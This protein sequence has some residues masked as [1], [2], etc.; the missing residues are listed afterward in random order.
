MRVRASGRSRQSDAWRLAAL[1]APLGLLVAAPALAQQQTVRLAPFVRLTETI[2]DNAGLRNDR[3]A[4]SDWITQLSPGVSLE[5]RGAR[6]NGSLSMSLNANHYGNGTSS[7]STFLTLN[8]SGKL[9]AWENRLYVDLTGSVS[10]IASSLFDPR[11]A[12]S[13]TGSNLSQLSVFTV[14][15][16]FTTRFGSTGS[17]RLRYMMGISDSGSA[18]MSRNNTQTWSFD[19]SDP[20][21]TGFLGWGF[22]FMDRSSDSSATSRQLK[23][24]T[25]RLTG[26]A[27]AMPDLMLRLIVGAESNNYRVSN[28]NS[29]IYGFGADWT[30]TPRTRVSGTIEDRFFGT[31]YTLAADHRSSQMAYR[32]SYGKD[33]SST[34]SSML[35]AMT[36]YELL[37]LQYTSRFPDATERE[38][39]VRQLIATQAPGQA[40]RI[41]AAQ[42]V[43]TDTTFL[44]ERLQVGATYSGP[45][46]SLSLMA[47]MSDRES[48]VDRDYAVGSDIRVG[49]TLRTTG[50]IASLGHQLTPLTSLNASFST[51]RS[52]NEGSVNQSS[53]SKM[54][55]AG[56]STKLAPKATGMLSARRNQ[57][58]G[59]VGDYTENAVFGN[60]V[61]QF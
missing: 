22:S 5:A 35:S 29:S 24:Q 18:A 15:P 59:S 37:M 2:T 7:D 56:L 25:T 20:R 23:Q 16:Y 14:S 31:G 28:Q 54:L 44:D 1:C 49:S 27:Q 10:R 45:R 61:L 38:A 30:P 48:L 34:S 58:T 57:G 41:T 50:M 43:L 47:F 33:A 8:G 51:S 32:I 11:P 19:A 9:M 39:F 40:D 3:D 12:D 4:K 13:V 42:T 55:M 17:V 60:V 26:M 36:L 46:N 53:Q 6:L 21:M 52:R